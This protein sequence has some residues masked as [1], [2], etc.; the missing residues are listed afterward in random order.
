MGSFHCALVI[1]FFPV[2]KLTLRYSNKYLYTLFFQI[3]N[4]F[5]FHL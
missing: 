4:V 3:Q 2:D 1:G 5:T